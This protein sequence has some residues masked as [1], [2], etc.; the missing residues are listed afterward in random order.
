[1]RRA[2]AIRQ[3]WIENAVEVHCH[4][5]REPLAVAWIVEGVLHVEVC[6]DEPSSHSRPDLSLPIE[7]P[8]QAARICAVV[9]CALR[10]REARLHGA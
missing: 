6:G 9:D 10:E 5:T 2:F 1:M 3:S 7:S 4:R 8:A